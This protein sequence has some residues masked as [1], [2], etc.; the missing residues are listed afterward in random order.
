[1]LRDATQASFFDAMEAER[2]PYRHHKAENKVSIL[3]GINSQILFRSVEDFERLRGTNLAWFGLDELT[4]MRREVWQRLQ[5]RLREPR[6]LRRQGIAAWTPKGFDWVYEMFIVPDRPAGHTAYLASPRENYHLP[7]DFYTNLERTYDERFY[8]QEVLGEYLPIHSGQ[9]YYGFDRTLN[10][11]PCPFIPSF[12]PL[13]W[14]LDFNISPMASVLCQ[15]EVG[16]NALRSGNLHL[17][18]RV[19]DEIMLMSSSIPEAC[20]AFEAKTQEY[21]R[22]GMPINVKVYGDASGDNRSHTTGASCYQI[23]KDFFKVRPQYK[24]SYHYKKSNP[25]VRD[26]INAVNAKLRA[27]DGTRSLFIDPRCKSLRRDFEQVVW[28]LDSNKQSSGNLDQKDGLTHISDA[29]GYFIEAEYGL[30]RSGNYG[31]QP[32]RIM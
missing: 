31:Y 19:L 12:G 30:T 29:L 10:I 4:Y 3:G 8:R 22:L 23:L 15:V 18:V 5:G 16:I 14:S 21:L 6:A 17:N 9:V 24:V 27:Q 20:Q 2:I 7:A 26:R 25:L 1:M 32:G 13:I 11:E 28:K